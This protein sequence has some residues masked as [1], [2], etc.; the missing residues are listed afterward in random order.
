MTL[1]ASHPIFNLSNDPTFPRVHGMMALH[2]LQETNER[3][4]ARKHI[5][6][7][8]DQAIRDNPDNEAKVDA[9]VGLLVQWMNT[10]YYPSKD[11]RLAQLKTL[12]TRQLVRDIFIGCAYCHVPTLFVS[13][14]AQL[15]AKLGFDDHADSIRTVAEVVAVLACTDAFD[16]Y[17]PS[18]WASLMLVNKLVFPQKLYEA[19]GRSMYIPPM[20]CEPLPIKNNFESPYLT[21]NECQILG[22]GNAH[23]EDICLD[24]LNTQNRI[25]LKLATDFL[26]TVEEEP[27]HDLDTTEKLQQWSEFKM[28]S[29][30]LYELLTKQGNRFWLTHKVDKRG[31]LYANGYHINTQGSSFKK[32]CLEL[33]NEELVEGAP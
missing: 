25:P 6:A 19:I 13:I 23:A 3:R 33:Y 16:V 31:R 17:K 26:S 11:K 8:I 14:T 7:Y 32:A 18:K 12:D 15:A 30:A 24:I 27:T 10:T 21:F 2:D 29:Y 1:S 4:F 20:V 5:N 28:H 9:G 22:R